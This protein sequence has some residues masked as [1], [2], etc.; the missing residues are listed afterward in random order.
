MYTLTVLSIKHPHLFT[1]NLA[2]KFSILVIFLLCWRFKLCI[3]M[4]IRVAHQHAI[5]AILDVKKIF[6]TTMDCSLYICVI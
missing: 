3:Q 5:T 1:V 6:L 2:H 4:N